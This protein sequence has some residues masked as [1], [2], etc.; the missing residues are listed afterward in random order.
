MKKLFALLLTA[1]LLL[2]VLA[3]PAGA[4]AETGDD[5]PV[6][7]DIGHLSEDQQAAI[8]WLYNTG[9]MVGTG[10]GQ[11]SPDAPFTRAMFGFETRNLVFLSGFFVLF[12]LCAVVSSLN[13]RTARLN[14]LA[15]IR[16]NPAFLGIMSAVTAVQ[17]AMVYLGGSVFRTAPLTLG[18]LGFLILLSLSVIL[19]E[20]LRKLVLKL[21]EKRPGAVREEK[22]QLERAA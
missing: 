22:G 11:F 2:P 13:V 7:Y 14:L 12:V 17:L 16:R 21:A 1:A 5:G 6:Y 20:T 19:P 18:E 3:I 8:V 9:M 10:E 4:S 15:D